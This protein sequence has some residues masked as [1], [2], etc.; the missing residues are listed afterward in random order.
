[1]LGTSLLLILYGLLRDC[2]D[3]SKAGDPPLTETD[4]VR[5]SVPAFLR[6]AGGG[7]WDRLCSEMAQRHAWLSVFVSS[8]DGP[9]RAYRAWLMCTSALTVMFTT[10][11]AY[12]LLFAPVDA[13]GFYNDAASC[14]GASS[15]PAGRVV[16]W[17]LVEAEAVCAWDAASGLCDISQPRPH[18]LFIL[19]V[20]IGASAVAG[21]LNMVLARVFDACVLPPVKGGQ[22]VEEKSARAMEVA[23]SMFSTP[24]DGNSGARLPPRRKHSSRWCVTAWQSTTI[25]W[26]APLTRRTI[27]VALAGGPVGRRVRDGT[28]RRTRCRRSTPAS[29]APPPPAP[30]ASP[31]STP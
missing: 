1:V 13:C 31:S 11:L 6:A 2:F 9:P 20:S 14:A 5:A 18:W 17:P 3:D 15:R 16:W 12:W 22:A 7:Y 30:R 4:V 27:G 26:R 21:P 23:E 8:P 19:L 29:P 10:L 28:G 25:S 24:A